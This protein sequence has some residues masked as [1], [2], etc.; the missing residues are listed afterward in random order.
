L[1][2]VRDHGEKESREEKQ[3]NKEETR[4]VIWE[5]REGN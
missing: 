3:G 1:W 2:E 4:E 5:S